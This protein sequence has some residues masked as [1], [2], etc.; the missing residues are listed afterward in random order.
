MIHVANLLAGEVAA[1]SANLRPY[2]APQPDQAVPDNPANTSAALIMDY[3]NG[4][5]GMLHASAATHLGNR[6]QEQRVEIAGSDA[7][8][9]G[10]MDM[11]NP[12]R[13][14]LSRRGQDDVEEL[15]VPDRLWGDV[16]RSIGKFDQGMEFFSKMSV[17]PRS[18]VDTILNEAKSE[19][20]FRDG[21]HV[22]RV[23]DAAL[24][25]DRTGQ[26]IEIG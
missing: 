6:G 24:E 10:V 14:Y 21:L 7:T 4:V 16:D 12:D 5:H 8:L 19:P 9:T 13:I 17:G 2:S 3:A 18:F 22:Q 25:S 15:A 26:K 23:I 20:S 1:V 11:F